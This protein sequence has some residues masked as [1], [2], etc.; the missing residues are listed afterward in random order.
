MKI[1]VNGW[2]LQG[3]TGVPRYVNSIIAHW[4][5]ELLARGGHDVT[6][7]SAKPNAGDLPWP[8]AALRHQILKSDLPML[9]WE[10]AVLG[11]R[12]RD[13]VLWCPSYTRPLYTRPKVVV[14][15]HDLGPA[16]YPD[17]YPA[18][19][20]LF[21]RHLHKWSVRHAV[22]VITDNENTKS[23]I[24]THYGVARDRIRVIPL[25]PAAAFRR[26][27]DPALAQATRIALFG[28]DLPFFLNVGTQSKRR[29][30][31]RILAGF[32]RFK[33]ETSKPHRLVLVGKEKPGADIAALA[34]SLGVADEVVHFE[35]VDDLRLNEI[36]NAATAF[37]MAA[38]YDATSLTVLE[39]QI[40]GTPVLLPNVPGLRA[41]SGDN[42]LVY[43]EPSE[44]TIA[45]ALSRI[46]QDSALR[47]QLVATGRRHA[48]SL[49]W[50]KT[51]HAIFD[52]LV[53][54]GAA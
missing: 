47:E 9:A 31:P 54:A 26:H 22:L 19:G 15:T 21:D 43:G 18:R 46:V 23:D 6:V 12:V 45:E 28:L 40:T 37:V 10:S 44:A 13:D 4:S 16:L 8:G 49:S 53:E 41:V 7:Y 33:R 11:P 14:T 25:A 20:R 29:N 17:L 27:D 5:A 3:W 38:T 2:R 35:F 36:Y 1:G 42:A 52:V 32:A 24:A 30:V 51:A 50:Q 34:R 48:E 39:A